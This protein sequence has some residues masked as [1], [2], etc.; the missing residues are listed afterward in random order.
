MQMKNE[1]S[2][3]LDE[4]KA[5]LPDADFS[6]IEQLFNTKKSKLLSSDQVKEQN[7]KKK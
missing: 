4:L 5:F 6:N 2:Q 1:M 7:N 3:K